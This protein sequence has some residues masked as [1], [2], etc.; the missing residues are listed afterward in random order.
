MSSTN[1]PRSI[2]AQAEAATAAIA[3]LNQPEQAGNPADEAAPVQPASAEPAQQPEPSA[4]QEP[5]QPAVET[6]DATYWQHRFNV[7]NGKYTAEV[8][9]LQRQVS[10]LT[11]AL[12]DA[13]QA[14]PAASAPQ[15]AQ[16]AIADLSSEEL[17]QFGP[18]LITVI[19][20]IAA[21]AAAPASPADTA[22][23]TSLREEVGQYREERQQDATARFWTDLGQAVPNFKAINSDPR[24]HAWLAEIDSITGQ[25]RQQLLESA[26]KD[27]SAYRVGALFNAFTQ[28]NPVAA[29]PAVPQTPQIPPEQVQPAASRVAPDTAQPSSQQRIWTSADIGQFYKDKAQGRYSPADAAALE[30]DIFA[31]QTQGRITA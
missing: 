7:I 8:P 5:A 6:R 17:E 13:R 30:A 2:Q 26:Q 27:L 25:S 29:Q 11:R 31:A 24:F 23:L 16:E 18:E 4:T 3:A 21:K 19:Q 28:T 9:Q 12:Q 14:Q 20:R 15:R 10:E 1:L 22:E